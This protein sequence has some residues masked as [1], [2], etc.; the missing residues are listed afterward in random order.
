[1]ALKDC[2]DCGK[3]VSTNASACPH[4]GASTGKTAKEVGQF[5]NFIALVIVLLI[6]LYV[7]RDWWNAKKATRELEEQRR[8]LEQVEKQMRSW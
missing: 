1:M 5:V 8:A 4:C 6:L 7:G 2:E 3:E